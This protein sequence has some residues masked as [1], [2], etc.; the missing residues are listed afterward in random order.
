VGKG[1]K[2]LKSRATS[3]ANKRPR[4]DGGRQLDQLEDIVFREDGLLAGVHKGM[5]HGGL[6][7]RHADI[8]PQD[9]QGDP[10]KG[11]RFVDTPMTRTPKEAE[12]GK[13]GL[14][15]GGR[16]GDPSP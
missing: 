2:E 14:M 3:P 5:V 4:P 7:H 15:T 10:G 6:H 11:G 13:L 9:R 16:S 1:A 8:H 12:A